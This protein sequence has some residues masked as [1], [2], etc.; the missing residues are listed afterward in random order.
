MEYYAENGGLF[1]YEQESRKDIQPLDS[2]PPD[3][4]EHEHEDDLNFLDDE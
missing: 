2:H 1:E 3:E 4:R